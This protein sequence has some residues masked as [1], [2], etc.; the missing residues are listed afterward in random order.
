MGSVHQVLQVLGRP[1]LRIDLLPVSGPVPM[2]PLV[3]VLIDWRYPDGI[4]AESL[5]IV[6]IFLNPFEGTP[7]VLAQI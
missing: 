1:E 5:N 6:E 3:K 2:V 4:E 7:A